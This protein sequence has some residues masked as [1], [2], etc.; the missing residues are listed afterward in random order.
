MLP[1][2]AAELSLQAPGGIGTLTHPESATSASPASL[3]RQ[4]LP[5]IRFTTWPP[6]PALS[7]R[8]RQPRAL[9][10]LPVAPARAWRF[11]HRGHSEHWAER[12]RLA[13]SSSRQARAP[14]LRRNRASLPLIDS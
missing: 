12:R 2:G 4:A 9:P 10:A 14:S 6:D 11:N 8:P 3:E 13:R 7:Q 5:H 1:I